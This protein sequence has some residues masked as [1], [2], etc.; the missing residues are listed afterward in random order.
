[1]DLAKE[2]IQQFVE[3][4]PQKA[5]VSLSVYGHVGTGQEKDKEKSCRKV[6][7]VYPLSAYDPAAFTNSLNQFK[8]ILFTF[9]E[10]KYNRIKGRILCK[11]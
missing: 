5:N 7:E 6:E 11:H 9:T 1:M 4:L 10:L 2:A 8:R 3:S